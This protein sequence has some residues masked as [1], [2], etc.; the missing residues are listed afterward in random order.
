MRS[1]RLSD[2]T[3]VRVAVSDADAQGRISVALE[4]GQVIV[5]PPALPAGPGRRLATDAPRTP[6]LAIAAALVPQPIP[7]QHRRSVEAKAPMRR[8]FDLLAQA[9]VAPNAAG[10][11]QALDDA[12]APAVPQPLALRPAP[13]VAANVIDPYDA[14]FLLGPILA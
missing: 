13:P 9:R 3:V 10:A 5:L 1:I 7:P 12:S 14:A 4:S 2:G 6:P 8:M 11:G